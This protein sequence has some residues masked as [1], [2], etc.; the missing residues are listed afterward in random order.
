M[1]NGLK[2][3][4]EKDGAIVAD[5]CVL[6]KSFG[7]RVLGLMG[8]R[9]LLEREGLLLEPCNSIHTF[10]MRFAI[11][12]AYLGRVPREQGAAEKRYRVMAIRRAVR[13]WKVDFPVF[14]AAAVL[15][16]AQGGA[17]ALAEGDILCLS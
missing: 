8:K 17:T 6:A 11:D 16:M 14:G 3:T 4:R 2:M 5:P 9:G 13:P 10:F 7:A 12:V 1:A 15:E